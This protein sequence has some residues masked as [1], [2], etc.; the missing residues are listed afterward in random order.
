[1]D[2]LNLLGLNLGLPVWYLT[3]P[4]PP[5]KLEFVLTLMQ[6]IDMRNQPPPGVSI[7]T[8]SVPLYPPVISKVSTRNPLALSKKKPWGN[9]SNTN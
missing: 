6:P 2:T 5:P 4:N 7:P 8:D 1:M 9:M 3:P